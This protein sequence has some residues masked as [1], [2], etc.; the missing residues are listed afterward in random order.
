MAPHSLVAPPAV[1]LCISFVSFLVVALRNFEGNDGDVFRVHTGKQTNAHANEA[2]RE[3]PP[4]FI[5]F[6]RPLL[7]M[8]YFYRY[9]VETVPCAV[10]YAEVPCAPL[11]VR[12]F[13]RTSFCENEHLGDQR[14]DANCLGKKI[15]C[16]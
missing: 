3:I 1:C 5:F 8:V 12:R 10:P 6:A 11:S 9:S 15:A 13:L 14:F 4:L 16:R 7:L 2:S